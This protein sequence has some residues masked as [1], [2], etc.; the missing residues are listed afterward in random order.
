[1]AQDNYIQKKFSD[2][3]ILIHWKENQHGDALIHECI[4]IQRHFFPIL[5]LR[6]LKCR[7]L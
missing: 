4:W 6:A 5:V 7:Y 1:M 2:V 3:S